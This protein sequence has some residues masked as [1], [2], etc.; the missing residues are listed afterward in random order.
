MQSDNPPS[1]PVPLLL[2]QSF[3]MLLEAQPSV[4]YLSIA[5]I[6]ILLVLSGL[7]SG[8]EV[9]FFSFSPKEL[10]SIKEDDDKKNDKIIELL[11]KP[12]YLLST[13]LITNNMINISIVILSYYVIKQILH[14]DDTM[15][16]M[17]G[18]KVDGKFIEAA[19]NVVLDTVI[20]LMFC[21]VMPKIYAANNKMTI[22]MLTSRPLL[23]L[24]TVCYPMSYVMVHSSSFIEKKI[25][26]YSELDIHDID[27][28][29]EMTVDKTAHGKDVD[30][31]KGIV[32]FGNTQAKQIMQ[33]RMDIHALDHSWDFSRVMDYVKKS[34]YSRLPVFEKSVDHIVGILHVK[35][36]LPFL[37]E[38]AD[39]NWQ[40]KTRE[41]LFVP[42]TKKI[43]DLLK[44][45]QE[46]RKHIVIVVDEYGGTSGII[47]LE[48][49]IEEVLGDI[50]DEFDEVDDFQNKQLDDHTFIFEGKMLLHDVA[51]TLSIEAEQFDDIRGEA[52]TL[53]GLVLEITGRMPARNEEIKS[54]A[55]TFKVLGLEKNRIKRILVTL[56]H[57]AEA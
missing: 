17:F 49:I 52:E 39:F 50:K 54:G 35:D 46:R 56:E 34:G 11:D 19:V 48:D 12:R 32:H 42:E 18:F 14:G 26:R 53:A 21:E 22:A 41:A 2:A 20:L 51:R 40:S 1:A 10:E 23:I 43:D 44:E 37:E 5:G 29:I 9:A 36:L 45:I 16:E 57:E 47:T 4:I 7:I 13:I 38:S 24:R 55:F 6:I 25:R 30:I 3:L 15:Y 33:A 31:L 8:S 28:A 27:Q